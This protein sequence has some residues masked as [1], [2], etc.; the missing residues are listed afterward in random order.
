MAKKDE[1]YFLH[2]PKTG[3]HWVVREILDVI[4]DDIAIFDKIAHYA[5]TPVTESSYLIGTWRDPAKRTVSHYCWLIHENLISSEK[6]TVND[7]F[8]WVEENKDFL[9]NFQSKNILSNGNA[10]GMFFVDD[11]TFRGIFK[12]NEEVLFERIRSFEVF[13]RDN[14]LNEKTASLIVD[15]IYA[16]FP[17]TVRKIKHR[18]ENRG[19]NT[20]D[21]SKNLFNMLN[22][23]EIEM[24]HHLNDV[25]SKVY[26][27]NSLFWNEGK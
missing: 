14:Q 23:E 17:E 6:L 25:D 5:W 13:I 8:D 7:F 4:R 22:K 18:Y 15:K 1:I 12:I 3:G 20:N 27:D 19:H 21:S 9:A 16:D 2:I 10:H 11:D 24:L 26:F